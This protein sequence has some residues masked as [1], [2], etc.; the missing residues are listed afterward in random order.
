MHQIKESEKFS[1]EKIKNLSITEVIHRLFSV[2][3]GRCVLK[4]T[5]YPEHT[6][7]GIKLTFVSQ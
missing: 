7:E 3:S 5:D 1:L 2:H 4:S 6:D